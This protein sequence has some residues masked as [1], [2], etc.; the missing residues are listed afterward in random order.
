MRYIYYYTG[1]PNP[2]EIKYTKKVKIKEKIGEDE[3][4]TIIETPYGELTRRERNPGQNV[5]NSGFPC[6]NKS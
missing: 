6:E 5:E 1:M 3:I 4:L 2:V